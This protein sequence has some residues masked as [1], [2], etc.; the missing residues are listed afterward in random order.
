[1]RVLFRSVLFFGFG[2]V[3]A[4]WPA[5]QAVEPSVTLAEPSVAPVDPPFAESDAALAVTPAMM[6]SQTLETVWQG[7]PI[8]V[9]LKV[10]HERRI[11]FPEPIADLDVPQTVEKNSRIVLTPTGQLHWTARAPFDAVRVLATSVSGTLYQLDISARAEG[12][13]PDQL[14]LRDPLAPAAVRPATSMPSDPAHLDRVARAL[15][16]DFLKTDPSRRGRSGTPG[17]AALARFA[18]AHYHGPERLI[19]PLEAHRVP[20]RPIETREWLRVQA[21]AL[22]VRPLAQWQSGTLYVTAVGVDNRSAQPITFDPRALRGD[23]AFVAVL[24]PTLAP[25][26]SGH[27]G[28][29][30]AVVTPQP[31]NQAVHRHSHAAHRPD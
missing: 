15:V 2:W 26:G 25:L 1:M 14:I 7:N 23:L 11:D 28:T 4:A 10:N 24:H 5:A 9:P 8:A 6:S 3:L 17:Y 21:A 12:E 27:Q 13:A 29:V 16:P 30:W 18:L 20:V 31:F 22:E 19:P